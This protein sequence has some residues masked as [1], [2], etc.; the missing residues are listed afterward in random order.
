MHGAPLGRNLFRE[1]AERR[2]R[3]D[4]DYRA[5]QSRICARYQYRA[6]EV[7]TP[8][9]WLLRELHS[10]ASRAY[11]ESHCAP[12]CQE[13]MPL[14]F[15]G[16]CQTAIMTEQ[17]WGWIRQAE[18]RVFDDRV[19]QQECQEFASRELPTYTDFLAA[20]KKLWFT[21]LKR[22]EPDAYAAQHE[23]SKR[24]RPR[25]TQPPADRQAIYKRDAGMCWI[26]GQAAD[27]TSFELD[28]VWPR[29]L[30]G[31]NDATNLSVAHRECN[32]RRSNPWPGMKETERLWEIRGSAKTCS[33]SPTHSE[34]Q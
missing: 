3:Y 30:G 17:F 15:A 21:A 31:A 18:L 32:I 5:E 29:S 33:V 10:Q 7:N 34:G 4:A 2:A 26:C 6:A 28:H 24:Q 27:E 25:K 19:F 12:S 22:V 20:W 23:W 14:V 8:S 9:F 11:R 13:L 1:E 16:D